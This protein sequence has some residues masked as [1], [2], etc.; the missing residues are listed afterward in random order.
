M[1][2]KWL[3]LDRSEKSVFYGNFVYIYLDDKKDFETS[4]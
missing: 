3:P 4:V 2:V 1:V